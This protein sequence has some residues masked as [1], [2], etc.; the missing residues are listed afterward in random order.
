M[1]TMV[2]MVSMVSM[3]EM[4]ENLAL[5]QFTKFRE[6]GIQRANYDTPASEGLL[7]FKW[8]PFFYY[9]FIT[10]LLDI[11]GATAMMNTEN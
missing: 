9:I 8:L 7:N 6:S 1:V 3:V 11:F 2:S 5:V 4:D 10:Y